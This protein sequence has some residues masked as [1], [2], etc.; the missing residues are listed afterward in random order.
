MLT[1]SW[2][3]TCVNP[4]ESTHT[5]TGELFMRGAL[6][7]SLHCGH[8]FHTVKVRL[9]IKGTSPPPSRLERVQKWQKHGSV[10]EVCGIT[11][12]A[13]PSSFAPSPKLPRAVCHTRAGL[14]FIRAWSTERLVTPSLYPHCTGSPSA[15]PTVTRYRHT[16]HLFIKDWH[17]LNITNHN[18]P[19]HEKQLTAHINGAQQLY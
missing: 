9:F 1:R 5:H 12:L 4:R 10:R 6:L 7:S 11:E 8:T 19:L 3:Q 15:V 2:T 14:L 17:V 13:S 16:G 18:K